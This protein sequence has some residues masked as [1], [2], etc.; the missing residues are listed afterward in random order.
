MIIPQYQHYSK[1]ELQAALSHA[2]NVPG[3]IAVALA[4]LIREELEKRK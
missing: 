4:A 2:R 1:Y 3:R